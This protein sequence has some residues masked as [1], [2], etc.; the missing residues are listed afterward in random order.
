MLHESDNENHEEEEEDMVGDFDIDDVVL[1]GEAGGSDDDSGEDNEMESDDDDDD[2]DGDEE[3]EGVQHNIHPRVAFNADGR[4]VLL[5]LGQLNAMFVSR[6]SAIAINCSQSYCTKTRQLAVPVL[7][8]VV[9]NRVMPWIRCVG[10]LGPTGW[11]DSLLTL[12]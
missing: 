9:A 10:D 7:D 8:S 2:D 12:G 5:H 6:S 11:R 1:W 3:G 4:P